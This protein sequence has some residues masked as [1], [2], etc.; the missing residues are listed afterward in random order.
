MMLSVPRG[1]AKVVKI[2]EFEWPGKGQGKIFC[3]KVTE[4]EKL[5]PRDV[6][7]SG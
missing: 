6:R 4:N 2:R 3:G 1:Q 5:V 7:F